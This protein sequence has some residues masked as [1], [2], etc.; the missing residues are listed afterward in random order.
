[1]KELKPCPFCGAANPYLHAN[2]YRPVFNTIECPNCKIEITV[3]VLRAKNPRG[4]V[5]DGKELSNRERL[6]EAWNRRTP[7]V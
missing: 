4:G 5:Y 7:D 3:P 2:E 1:M 6:I